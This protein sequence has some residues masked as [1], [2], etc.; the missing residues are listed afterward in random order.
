MVELKK[1]KSNNLSKTANF[2][3]ESFGRAPRL[4]EP[5]IPTGDSST[6]VQFLAY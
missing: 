2:E 1:I 5:P 6:F 4:Q 3:Y